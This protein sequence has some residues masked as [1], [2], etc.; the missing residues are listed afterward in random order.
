MATTISFAAKE[1]APAGTAGPTVDRIGALDFVRGFALFGILLMNIT[2]FGLSNA[3]YNP[4]NNG[5]STGADLT[6]WQVIQVGFDGTQRALFSLLFGAGIILLTRRLEDRVPTIASDIFVRRNLWLI[7]FGIFNASILI[8]EGDILYMYGLTALFAYGFRK[9][10]PR[11]LIG[12]GIFSM[13]L[14]ANY[15]IGVTRDNLDAYDKAQAAQ[16]VAASGAALTEEQSEAIETWKELEEEHTKPPAEV[17]KDI[18]AHKAGWNSTRQAI[19]PVVEWYRTT[20]YY[21][22]FGDVFGMMLIG[23]ALFRLGVLTLER[24]SWVYGAMVVVGYGIGIPV[25]LSETNWIIQNNFSLISFNQTDITMDV[26]RLTTAMGHLG[27]LLLLYRSGVLGWFRKAMCA[28][29]QLALTNYLSHSLVCAIIFT[30]FG[31]YGELQRH[32][33]Y[34]IVGAIC[35]T[36]LI[37]SPIWLTYFRFGPMEWIWRSLTYWKLQGFRRAATA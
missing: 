12:I 8:W 6:A 23:M 3:Y 15:N 10:S 9:L 28:V 16:A 33:L 11:W 34:Y 5:G 30:G 31:L 19:D 17:A 29:G 14:I 35:L 37:I 26:G 27:L 22:H 21:H 1:G 25:N 4:L 7:G 32:E 18:A 2:A 13:L 20:F 36:Q 24:P